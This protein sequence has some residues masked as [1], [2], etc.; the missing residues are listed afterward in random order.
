MDAEDFFEYL[1]SVYEVYH[2]IFLLSSINTVS[3]FNK[4]LNMKPFLD[5]L[6]KPYLPLICCCCDA[7]M[8]SAC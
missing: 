4:L 8:N 3:Y 7:F 5:F 6:R 2:M 1:F